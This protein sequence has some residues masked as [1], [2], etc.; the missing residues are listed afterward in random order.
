LASPWPFLFLG[1]WGCR[2]KTS[3]VGVLGRGLADS[4]DP[5][6]VFSLGLNLPIC[7]MT[8]LLVF[9]V[10]FSSTVVSSNDA[11]CP[12]LEYT[13]HKRRVGALVRAGGGVFSFGLIAT[14][15][16]FQFGDSSLSQTQELEVLDDLSHLTPPCSP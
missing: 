11:Q 10:I 8:R 15:A 7:N 16:A 4:Q 1:L 2:K 3:I 12:S 14:L 13:T 6:H 5:G 9:E